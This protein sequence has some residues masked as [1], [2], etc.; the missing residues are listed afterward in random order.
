MTWCIET[1]WMVF[2]TN[3]CT[4]TW[5]L[6]NTIVQASQVASFKETDEVDPSFDF[7]DLPFWI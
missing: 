4:G 6:K 3:H 2:P 7:W 5:K 1:E